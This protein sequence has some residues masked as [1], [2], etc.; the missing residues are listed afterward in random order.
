MTQKNINN[1]AE[2]I[3]LGCLAIKKSFSFVKTVFLNR[4]QNESHFIFETNEEFSLEVRFESSTLTCLFDLNMICKGV[5]LFLD[6][7]SELIHYIDYCSNT[8]PCDL[9]L[10]GWITRNTII[11]INTDTQECSLSILPI[12]QN[13]GS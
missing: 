13:K 6:D 9:N 2:Q 12:R 8:Y 1:Y 7:T 11:R 5:F 4:E 10:K 3:T